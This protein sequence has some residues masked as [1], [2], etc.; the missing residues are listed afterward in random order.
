MTVFP[1][2]SGRPET[3][4]LNVVAGDVRPNAAIMK[5]DTAGS[6]PYFAQRG[7]HLVVDVAGYFTAA[8]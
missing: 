7:A 1:T 8:P 3:S 5:V 2:A 6:I 4:T